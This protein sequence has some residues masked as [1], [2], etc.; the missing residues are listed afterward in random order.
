MP[1]GKFKD[2]TGKKYG[3]LVVV[4]R[5]ENKDDNAQWVCACECGNDIIV[6]G[7]RLRGGHTESCG[8]L[9]LEINSKQGKVANLIHGHARTTGASPTYSSWRAMVARC[10]NEKSDSYYRYG[11]IGITIC[12]RWLGE[13]GFQNFLADMGKRPEG[14][15]LGRF[16]DSG[17][18]TR[19]NCSWQT[20][21]EQ[22]QQRRL[23]NKENQN[24]N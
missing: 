15:T 16:L 2:E 21:A 20:R 19:D 3:R 18:Y 1:Q 7:I 6:P 4:R 8:C 12:E 13:S 17:D 9:K 24:G 14:T 23:K 10:T 22:G 5:V 11:G